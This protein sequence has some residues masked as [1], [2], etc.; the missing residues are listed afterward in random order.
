MPLLQGDGDQQLPEILL[1][2]DFSFAVVYGATAFLLQE[3]W[4]LHGHFQ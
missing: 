1:E 2:N 3:D 4:L